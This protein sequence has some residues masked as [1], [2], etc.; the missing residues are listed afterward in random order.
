[1]CGITGVFGTD[2]LPNT[3]ECINR[4]TNVLIHRGPD[5]RGTW[6]DKES[7]IA[8]G[9]RR[10]SI[11]D[12]SEAGHQP[13]HSKCGN[14]V[15]SFNGE[16][17]N[18]LDLRKELETYSENNK[19]SSIAWEGRSDTET[20]LEGFS[21]FG[22]K[23]TLIKAVGMFAIA[24]WDKDN[25]KLYLARDRFGEKPL[26]YG[27]SNKS[28]I[29]GSELKALKEFDSFSNDIDRDSL[30]IFMRHGYIPSPRS[31]YKDI[32][33]LEPGIL[34]TIDIEGTDLNH[35]K[36]VEDS[37]NKDIWWSLSESTIKAKQDIITDEVLGI[38]ELEKSLINS[39]SLQSIADV[40]LGAFLSGGL[41]SSLIVALMQSISSSK[42]NTFSIGFK[43][44]EYNEAKYAKAVAKHLDT[45]HTELYLS[46]NDA[47]ELIPKL[48]ELFDEPFGDSSQLPTYLVC[49]MA[50]KH[51]TVAL[52]G[53]AGDELFGGYNR[54]LQAPKV[55]KII[56][57]LPTSILNIFSFII[58]KLPVGLINQI[59]LLLP[60][61]YKV[62]F[63]G[64]KLL[65]FID[66]INKFKREEDLYLSLVSEWEDPS[67]LVLDSKEPDSLLRNNSSWP[68]LSSF[69]ERMMFLD[70]STYLP[71][72]ILVKVD[73]SSMA[74]SLE[75][76]VPFLDHRVVEIALRLSLDQKI[77]N[78]KGKR[79]LRKILNKYV[80]EH[81]I[82][83]PK[84]GFGI[85]L[86]EWL[87]GPLRE[88][89]EK[90]IDKDRLNKE[91]Y[92][93][94]K[95]VGQRWEEHLSRERNWEHSLWSV[96]MFQAWLESQ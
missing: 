36:K 8:F 31:I 26:Y 54:H 72:D 59:G 83:R 34:L 84:Q 65:K 27:W 15:L 85:P 88:W 57:C 92:L 82:K 90:L 30:N 87:R 3:D 33:K 25:R 24:L 14:F 46:F 23:D 17:Y 32:Y 51:V 49:L 53:D 42:I 2:N 96:L 40:P 91:G 50:K 58:L 81:L 29:F 68:V 60:G 56:S 22:I 43:E 71:D 69:E 47:L 39:I 38:E 75:T 55:W 66:G 4:M 12:L 19:E 93:N 64:D 5:D 73:R 67:S 7:G 28:F 89:A 37:L 6:I 45:N 61:R 9:H 52:S 21:H 95:L 48:P 63:L 94:S 62:I 78:G 1:M 20:L 79:I 35:P 74:A 44:E 41:D 86:A 10:L 80:P 77:R 18:H 76:R 11:L 70:T 13:M 16:I